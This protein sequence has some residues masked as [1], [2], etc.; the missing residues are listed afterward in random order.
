[1]ITHEICG[2]IYTMA[3]RKG[4]KHSRDRSLLV[5]KCAVELDE[6]GSYHKASAFSWFN[7]SSLLV[8]ANDFLPLVLTERLE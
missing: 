7:M 6:S 1:M 3:L 8:R 5:N 4:T 2:K